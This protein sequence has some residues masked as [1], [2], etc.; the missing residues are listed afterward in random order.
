M[1]TLA[2]SMVSGLASVRL[3]PTVTLESAAASEADPLDLAVGLVSVRLELSQ[4]ENIHQSCS[5][6]LNN[7]SQISTSFQ[8]PNGSNE[9]H[10]KCKA[11]LPQGII[12]LSSCE[13]LVK[14]IN[15]N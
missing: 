5:P 3:S 11:K 15:T 12:K 4:G 14:K 7:T 8:E 2:D 1:G 13:L 6:I 10:K 9:V